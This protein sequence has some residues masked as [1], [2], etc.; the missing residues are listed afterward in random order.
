MKFLYY[1]GCSL[2]SSGRAYDESLQAVFAKL[3]FPIE[4]L[5]E[6]SCCGATA[7]MGIDESKA[8]ALAARNL[9]LAEQAAVDDEVH[10]IAPC[11][12]CYLVL[13]KAQKYMVEY[14]SIG[15]TITEAL[16]AVGLKYRSRVKVRHPLDV[17]VNEV[18]LEKI[19]AAVSRALQ[20]MKV[21]CYYGCQIVRPFA[22][23]D[24]QH[25]PMTMDDLLRACGAET[26]DWPAKARCCGAMLT[27]TI[28]EVG[29]RRS[30][31]ILHE[32][33]R[34][35][36]DAVATACPLCQFNLEC[37][38]GPMSRRYHDDVKMP[39]AYFTQIM[40][41]AMGLDDR[42]LGLHRLFIPLRQHAAAV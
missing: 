24:D 10:L 39:V 1:P 22:E 18:G 36:V 7:Y 6:W 15:Q 40:G 13:L 31:M 4:E 2:E 34:R 21:A 37:F 26:L 42:T 17:L 8:F 29:Q 38:Q 9:A 25:N 41:K 12:A 14:K 19:H 20:G 3:D 16:N 23:F 5:P 33:I 35:G 27:G 28:E 32:A 30:Y 11:A